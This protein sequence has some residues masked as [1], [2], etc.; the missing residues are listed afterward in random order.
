PPFE[1]TPVR[2]LMGPEGQADLVAHQIAEHGRDGPQF[3]ELVEE[4]ADDVLDLLV[5]IEVEATRGDPDIA[6]RRGGEDPAPP[7]LV[8]PPLIEPGTHDVQLGFAHGP[9]ERCNITHI[10]STFAGPGSVSSR[11][12]VRMSA[13]RSQP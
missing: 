12:A 13:A 6:Q 3:I 5:G 4:Q 10:D 7:R 8:E 11:V 9:L 2:S 1:L